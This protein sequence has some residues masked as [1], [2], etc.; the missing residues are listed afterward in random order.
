MKNITISEL[1]YNQ[2]LHTIEQLRVQLAKFTSNKPVTKKTEK[3]I[4]QRLHGILAM[5]KEFDE[6]QILEDEILKKYLA[7]E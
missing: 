2:L 4:A 5:P 7:N 3:S 6:K 1:E